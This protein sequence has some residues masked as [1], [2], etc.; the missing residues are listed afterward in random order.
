MQL[1][2]EGAEGAQAA[3]AEVL[4][5]QQPEGDKKEGEDKKAEAEEKK[6]S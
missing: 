4:K 6:I 1:K 5:S 3:A 2:A